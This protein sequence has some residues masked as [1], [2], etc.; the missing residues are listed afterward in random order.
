MDI[1]VNVLLKKNNVDP[2]QLATSEAS[3][4]GSTLYV[5]WSFEKKCC[6]LI[7]FANTLDLD[8][9]R[10]YVG[11]DLNP[12]HL[13]LIMFLKEFFEKSFNLEK[14]SADK[15]KSMKNYLAC[16][17]LILGLIR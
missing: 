7:T 8:Q 14:N 16:K 11:P 9:D 17:E 10:Q 1:V 12:N 4:S 5:V 15:N 6:L 3:W 13:R 2:D